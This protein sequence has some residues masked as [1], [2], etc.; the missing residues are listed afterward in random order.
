MQNEEICIEWIGHDI[1]NVACTP[2]DHLFDIHLDSRVGIAFE[3]RVSVSVCLMNDDGM[4]WVVAQVRGHFSTNEKRESVRCT[5]CGLGS[6]N[7]G[8]V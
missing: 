1:L 6:W 5:L 3:G 8:Y 2:E 7:S 4:E